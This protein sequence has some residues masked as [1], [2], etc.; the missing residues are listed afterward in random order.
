MAKRQ[1][2]APKTEN[3]TEEK[4]E[5]KTA[6]SPATADNN[7]N[8]LDW[9]GIYQAVVPYADCEG[10]KTK[11]SL[12]KSGEFSRSLEYLG[13]SEVPMTDSGTYTWNPEGGKIKLSSADGY[14]QSYQVG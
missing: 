8:S 12:F 3:S 14:T 2:N 4:T 5:S 6:I 1:R 7:K 9:Y 11:I 13:K 10:I